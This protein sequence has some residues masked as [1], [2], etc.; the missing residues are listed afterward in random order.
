MNL[1]VIPARG[2]SKRIPRKNIKNFC[3]QAMISYSI[4]AAME[5]SVFDHVIVSTDDD[6]IAE[7]AV[8]YGA[9]VPFRRP[10]ALSDD[11]TPT[12][13]VILHA[14]EHFDL[15]GIEFDNICCIYA[16]SPMLRS[17]DIE[18]SLELMKKKKATSCIPVTEFNSTPQR[19]IT[20]DKNLKISWKYPQFKL[21]R[22]QDLETHFH[23]IGSFYW[24]GRE[25]WLQGDISRGIGYEIPNWRAVDIDNISDWMRAEVLFSSTNKK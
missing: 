3:G 5:S 18:R 20:L 15:A 7:I 16:C 2:G 17:E 25:T 19:A 24:A 4:Q 10:K 6:E 14:I 22:T 11:F 21:T 1:A 13:P 23:D 8:K 12:V 9:E